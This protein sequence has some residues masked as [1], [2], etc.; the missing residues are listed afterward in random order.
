[1]R[2]RCN[3][4]SH[5]SKCSGDFDDS[6]RGRDDSCDDSFDDS[7]DDSYIVHAEADLDQVAK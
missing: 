2:G 6:M 5:S 4:S 7:F 1:M 3:D